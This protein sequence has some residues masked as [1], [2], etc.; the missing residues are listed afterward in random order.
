MYVCYSK[1]GISRTSSVPSLLFVS[2]GY[3]LDFDPFF[4]IWWLQMAFIAMCYMFINL[5]A[6]QHIAD[7]PGEHIHC[8]D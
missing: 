4:L 6:L 7:R 8:V 5:F 3:A 2:C 1:V